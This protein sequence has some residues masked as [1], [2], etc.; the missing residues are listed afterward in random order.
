MEFH[1]DG[2]KLAIGKAS[3]PTLLADNKLRAVAKA[4][5][6]EH[7]FDL[8]ACL[9]RCLTSSET[10]EK[11]YQ[12]PELGEVSIRVL[13][14]E[15]LPKKVVLTRN[16]MV[17]T[18]SLEHFGDK[19]A[20]FP[21]YRDFVALVTPVDERGS[22]FI[23]K[24]EDPRH[25]ALSAEGLA[26]AADRDRARIVMKR[27]AERI[28]EAIKANALTQFESEVPVDELRE[29]FATES[30][31]ENCDRKGDLDDPERLTYKVAP[32]KLKQ[33]SG[34]STGEGSTGG[35]VGGGDPGPGPHG[36]AG[37]VTDSA[38]ES[39]HGAGG[40]HSLKRIALQGVRNVMHSG[41][42]S[43][44]SLFF[45][46]SESGMADLAVFATG[47]N[48]P[49]LI[50]IRSSDHGEVQRGRVKLAVVAG[51]RM[52]LSVDFEEPYSGPLDLRMNLVSN[53]AP[54]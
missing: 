38:S 15:G 49:D 13:V 48:T 1:L 21:M 37:T 7:D 20:R 4:E 9:Y 34:Y 8:A 29:F 51:E 46:A 44:R 52:K 32:P 30:T 25:S 50:G 6:R 47:L 18:D 19:L 41:S 12:L 16:G 33:P 40:S 24:L 36:A 27:L 14:A 42:A 39:R 3:L 35:G 43:G 5:G 28:R 10:T 26:S 17:I 23:K 22:E 53:G 2:G 11:L 54:E 31:G 45:T